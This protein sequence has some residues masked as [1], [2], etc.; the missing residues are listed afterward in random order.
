MRRVLCAV[1]LDTIRPIVLF[2]THLERRAM[3]LKVHWPIL[4]RGIPG[5]GTMIPQ[6][7]A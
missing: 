2:S 1:Q 7:A 3:S 6:G 5:T 4:S